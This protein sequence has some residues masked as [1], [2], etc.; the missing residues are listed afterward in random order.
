[1][2]T[3]PDRSAGRGKGVD[4]RARASPAA[5]HQRNP[6]GIVFRRMDL[7]HVDADQRG[8]RRRAGGGPQEIASVRNGR[9]AGL[10]FAWIHRILP[11][12]LLAGGR[13]FLPV[14]RADNTS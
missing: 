5:A 10:C 14:I 12:R 2:A 3:R 8:G 11:Q 1:M 13:A 7:R 9:A 6:N 4:R